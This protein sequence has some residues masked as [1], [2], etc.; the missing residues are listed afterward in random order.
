MRSPWS[1]T[2]CAGSTTARW[3]STAWSPSLPSRTGSRAGSRCRVTP[4]TCASGTSPTPPSPTASS[5]R[6]KPDAIVHFG[7]QRSAPYSMIDREHAVYTQVNN[8]VGNL[9][10]MYAIQETD[11]DIHLVKLGTMGEYGY[12]NIDIEEGFIEITHKGRTDLMPYPKQ[13]GSFYHLSKVHDSH[14]IMFGCRIWGLR[15]T[16]LNQGIVYGQSTPGDRRR[17]AAGDPL[18]L[19]RRV[20]HRAQ[21]LLRAGG[22]RPPPDR[23]RRRRP[24]PRHAQHPRHA[25]LRDPG[26]REPRRPRRVP[27]LQP[28]HRV[29]LRARDGARWSRRSAR[30]G[31]TSRRACPTPGSRTRSTTSTPPTPS[32]STSGLQPHLLTDEVIAEHPRAGGAPPEPGGC[33]GHRPHGPVAVECQHPDDVRRDAGRVVPRGVTPLRSRCSFLWRCRHAG[34]AAAR[35]VDHR[36][37]RSSCSFA[38]VVVLAIVV[39]GL[40]QVSRQSA[41]LRRQLRPHAGRAGHRGGRP[42]QCHRRHGAQGRQRPAVADPPGVAGDARRRG[43]ADGR[44]GG[45]GAGRRRVDPVGQRGDPVRRRLRRAGPGRDAAAGRRLRVPRHAAHC[46]PAGAPAGD[47]H[48]RP[49]G[50][51]ALLS[52]TAG[53]QPHCGRRRAAGAFRRALPLGA[54]LPGHRCRATGGCRRR[55]G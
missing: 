25:R 35:A 31:S 29:V 6:A 2:W 46:P 42:V 12:P 22:H 34:H 23:L 21:P 8:V 27:G 52:A 55:S 41:G 40:T 15:A 18:R 48:G 38:A 13:P 9:N 43:A 1:T 50:A 16:D 36:P 54:A 30:P 4:S 49:S 47:A 3:A 44:R 5:P 32:C 17:P 39:G 11:P 10:V 51:T 53:H 7:E 14:N 26:A 28:V 33:P 20:R 19:R 37:G 45:P 24:D